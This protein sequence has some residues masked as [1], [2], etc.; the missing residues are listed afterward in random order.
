MVKIGRKKNRPN[1]LVYFASV[2]WRTL[3]EKVRFVRT[4]DGNK[5]WNNSRSM[6]IFR[7]VQP[8]PFYPVVAPTSGVG[9]VFCSSG[10]YSSGCENFNDFSHECL[11]TTLWL[12]PQLLS[13]INNIDGSR[14][15]TG[16]HYYIHFSHYYVHSY[17]EKVFF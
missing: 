6:T 1:T 10:N 4:E 7:C 17:C 12:C 5:T 11:R 14:L 8:M 13:A 9:F 16:I 15:A 3:A 2:R